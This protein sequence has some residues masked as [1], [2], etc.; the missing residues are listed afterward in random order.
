[1][2][3]D[4]IRKAH[5]STTSGVNSAALLE[6]GKLQVVIAYKMIYLSTMQKDV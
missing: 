1:M 3:Q 4:K 5:T 6:S 2:E